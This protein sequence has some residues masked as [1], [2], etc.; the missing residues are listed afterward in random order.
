MAERRCR[1]I[2]YG[3]VYL[4]KSITALI[5]RA[6]GEMS[7]AEASPTCTLVIDLK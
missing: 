4:I 1:M 6:A 2:C 3:M 7:A 5:I